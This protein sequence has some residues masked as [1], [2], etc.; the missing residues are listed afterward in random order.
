MDVRHPGRRRVLLA[1]AGLAACPRAARGAEPLRRTWDVDGLSRQALLFLPEDRQRPAPVVFGFHG[2]GGSAQN[3]ARMFRLHEVWPEAL[4]VYM[5]GIPTPGRVTDLEGKRTGWQH[6][7]GERGDRDLKFF[8][9]VLA[10]V[11]K[12]YR[13]DDARIYATGH[14]NGGGFTY[15]LWSQRPEVFA[16][17]APSA[18]GGSVRDLKPLPV[19]HIAGERDTVAQISRQ[20]LLMAAVHRINGCEETGREWARHCT[21]YP[22]PLGTPFVAFVHPGDHKYP[23]EAPPLVVRFFQEHSRRK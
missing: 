20:Q 2:H 7:P 3:A 9:A 17:V 4:V 19:M 10:G 15:L 21:L 1:A 6:D 18:G 12:E 5:Q 22:S 13:V 16:A 14:S 11:R 23:A 8:D